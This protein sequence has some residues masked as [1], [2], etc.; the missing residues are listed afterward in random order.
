MPLQSVIQ[1]LDQYGI[2]SKVLQFPEGESA[3]VALAAK[4]VGCAPEKIAK[5]LAVKYKE[6]TALIVVAGDAKLDNKKFKA[7]FE[8]KPRMLSP[9]EA[10][11]ITGHPVGGVCP[12]DLPDGLSVYLDVSLKRFDSVFP[13]C[14]SANSAVEIDLKTLEAAS[15]SN[16]WID[17]CSNWGL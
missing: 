5:T 10:L 17:V 2:G 6:N 3:T 13:A 15:K 16:G 1:Y 7:H 9:D 11:S 4:A 14:G 12:F 8:G